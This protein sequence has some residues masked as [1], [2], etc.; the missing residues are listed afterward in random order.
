MK[1]NLTTF[2]FQIIN[3]VL[4]AYI[5]HRVLYKPIRAI[6]EKRKRLVMEDVAECPSHEGGRD[7]YKG[8][9]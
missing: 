4:L 8:E 6:M 5:L 1:L 3:F 2:I 7:N 9:V